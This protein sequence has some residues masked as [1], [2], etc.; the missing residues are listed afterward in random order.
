MYDKGATRIIYKC[1]SENDNTKQQIYLGSSFEAINQIPFGEVYPD[2]VQG[3]YPNYKAALKFYWINDLGNIEIAPRA[4]LILYP[5]YPEVRLSGFLQS[6]RL[7]PR[8]QLQP[9]RGGERRF[10]NA[11]DGRVIVL[12]ICP[13]GRILAYLAGAETSLANEL[14]SLERESFLATKHAL[15]IKL[16]EIMDRG[17]IA[18]CRMNN[19][20]EIVE[21]NAR[22]AGGYTLEACMGIIPNGRSEPDWKGWEIKAYASN[23]ITLMTPEPDAGYY[24]E[25]RVEQ[26]V[27]RYGRIRPGGDYYFTGIH[28]CG[29]IQ[30]RTKLKMIL[31]G[32]DEQTKKIVNVTGGLT[33]LDENDEPAAIWTYAKLIEHW[34]RKHAHAVYV[35]YSKQNSHGLNE[36]LYK[37]P[38]MLGERSDFINFLEAFR[39]E[40]IVYDPGSKV[41]INDNGRIQTK[42][43]NQFRIKATDIEILYNHFSIQNITTQL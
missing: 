42:S 11:K 30:S 24:G 14:I 31:D 40:K 28:K 25:Y 37:S 6:C 9:I 2:N 23:K 38:V 35:P 7:A 20:G 41:F 29:T 15:L 1:L 12:G 21:Y 4:Q 5:K 34:G 17:W 13:N 18:A 36:Y 33:L 19:R 43:R 10:Y 39:Q 3:K 27:R 26:F 8:E 32:Y 16:K 22:N